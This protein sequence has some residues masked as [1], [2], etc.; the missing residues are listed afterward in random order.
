MWKCLL[1]GKMIIK[2]SAKYYKLFYFTK[3]KMQDGGYWFLPFLVLLYALLR[4]YFFSR[5]LNLNL[6]LFSD[7][8]SE[9]GVLVN[10]QLRHHD[11][12]RMMILALN[13]FS[14]FFFFD[15]FASYSIQKTHF[16]R[17]ISRIE[18]AL[19]FIQFLVWSCVVLWLQFA[20]IL[21]IIR[22]CN[23]STNSYKYRVM[24]DWTLKIGLGYS[25]KLF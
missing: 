17:W 14:H 2:R 1:L 10:A 15:F 3:S 5:L 24:E 4:Y 6:C 8:K 9:P 11:D 13:L 18:R 21:T 22:F 16:Q 19:K 25:N 23:H 7:F 12:S 20:K